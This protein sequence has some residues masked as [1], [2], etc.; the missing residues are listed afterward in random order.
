M[1]IDKYFKS[2][3][4][5]LHIHPRPN[6]F[7]K[8]VI[9]EYLSLACKQ[10][11]EC[12]GLLEHGKRFIKNHQGVLENIQQIKCFTNTC[13]NVSRNFDIKVFKGIELDYIDFDTNQEYRKYVYTILGNN[14]DY[15][16][17]SVHGLSHNGVDAYMDATLNLVCNYPISILGHFHILSENNFD[18][19]KFSKIIRVMKN[20]NIAFEWNSAPRYRMPQT[21]K[22]IIFDILMD[23]DLP[24]VYGSD[25]HSLKEIIT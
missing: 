14:L 21:L 5:D 1:S 19:K 11:L 4:V 13:V 23:F 17:G 6:C 15:I 20:R 25:A 7:N 24:Y 22:S 9:G 2:P 16:V 8:D 3:N 10:K 12:V 18:I